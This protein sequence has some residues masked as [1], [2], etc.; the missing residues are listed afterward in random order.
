M[1]VDYEKDYVEKKEK[2]KEKT[3]APLASPSSSTTI[4]KNAPLPITNN[5]SEP[6]GMS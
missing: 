1:R 2:K 6:G 3:Y 5:Q 4:C